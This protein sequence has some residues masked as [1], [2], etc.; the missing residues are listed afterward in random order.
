MFYICFYFFLGSSEKVEIIYLSLKSNFWVGDRWRFEKEALMK[1][2][3]VKEFCF[4]YDD[5]EDKIVEF[6]YLLWR[7]FKNKM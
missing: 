1:I 7:S 2:L 4:G 3:G 5:Y 6:F